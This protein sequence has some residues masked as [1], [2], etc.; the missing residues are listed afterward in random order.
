MLD[1]KGFFSKYAHL[2]VSEKRSK[3]ALIDA[4]QQVL[5]VTIT[6]A[7]IKIQNK[8]VTLTVPSALRFAIMERKKEILEQVHATMGQ[9][10]FTSIR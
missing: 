8:E 7:Q 5:T 9:T 2:G 3:Q 6:S 1:L 10:T 4:I